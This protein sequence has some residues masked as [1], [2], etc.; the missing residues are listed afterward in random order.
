MT[1]LIVGVAL[2]LGI[3]SAGIV[4]LRERLLDRIGEGAWKGLYS[5]VSLVGL[6]AIVYGYAAARETGTPLWSPPV[7]TRH[8]ALTL[9]LPVFPLVFAAYVPGRIARGLG[10]PMLIGTAIWA[11]AH[12]LAN[13]MVHDLVLFGAFFVWAVLDLASYRWRTARSIP[14][15]R[16]G[17]LNDVIAV[18]GGLGA[19]ALFLLYAHTWLF[20]VAPLP[21]LM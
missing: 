21:S 5:V 7:W 16:P 4:G 20:G 19:Y 13:G 10:H 8:L 11:L 17:P 15:A 2:F 18:G 12:L 6:V 14:A 9:M 3:H 1:L